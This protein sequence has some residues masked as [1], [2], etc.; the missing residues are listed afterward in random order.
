MV[1]NCDPSE[2]AIAAEYKEFWDLCNNIKTS[3]SIASVAFSGN[4]KVW[5][6]TSSTISNTDLMNKDDHG[7][8][9]NLVF[10]SQRHMMELVYV[11]LDKWYLYSFRYECS[12]ISGGS[13]VNDLLDISCILRSIRA[14]K[15][16]VRVWIYCM[17]NT[18][19]VPPKKIN[20]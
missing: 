3:I 4:L 2:T 14:K 10:H 16:S 1:L 12:N 15:T 13:K 18:T 11:F 5:S 7:L 20:R 19:L 17:M 6:V 9:L 8:Y